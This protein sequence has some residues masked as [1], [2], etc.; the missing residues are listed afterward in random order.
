[1]PVVVPRCDDVVGR[2]NDIKDEADQI[3]TEIK[4]W[5]T[6]QLRP[7]NAVAG[8]E[9]LA[10]VSDHRSDVAHSVGVKK[11]TQDIEFWQERGPVRLH[12]KQAATSGFISDPLALNR[13][14]CEWLLD[15]GVFA[16]LQR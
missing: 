6:R 16:G 5:S 12:A 1:M 8:G 11:L 15:H 7:V 2:S 9:P 3:S 14:E 10:E 4:H 13:I